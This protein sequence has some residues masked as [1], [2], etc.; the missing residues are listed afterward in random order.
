[1]KIFKENFGEHDGQPVTAFTIVNE[2]GMEVTSIDYGCIISKIIAPDRNGVLENVVLGFDSLQD[3]LEHSPYFGA[4]IGRFAGRIK[5]AEFNLNNQTCRLA[6]NNNGNHLHGGLKG[7]DKVFW[8]AETRESGDSASIEFSYFSKDGEEGYPGNLQMKVTYTLNND[9]AFTISYEGV[10][11]QRTVLNVT[12]HSYFNL[13]GN[14][15]RDILD[16]VLTLKSSQFIELAEDLIPTG[17]VLPVDN[18]PFDFQSG[19]KI[20][21]GVSSEHPQNILAGKGYDHPFLL[22][23]NNNKEIILRDPESGR[24]LTIETDEPAVVLYTGTQLGDDFSIRG[25]KSRKYLGLCLETQGLP[26][27]VH[28]PHFPSSVLEKG[29]KYKSVTKYTFSLD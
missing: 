29:E 3:Y 9:N 15:K 12:N 10:S 19:R 14:I 21:D 17:Q 4:V 18:T 25:V 24:V 1:M 28:Q 26:D 16:H 11:D 8:N 27:S 13:S 23:E 6:K 7:F 20:N 2:Q 22:A 5:N